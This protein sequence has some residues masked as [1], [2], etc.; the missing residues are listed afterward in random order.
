MPKK[1]VFRI[2]AIK[3]ALVGLICEML[4]GQRNFVLSDFNKYAKAIYRNTAS[5]ILNSYATKD[6]CDDESDFHRNT[7]IES[8]DSQMLTILI[9]NIDTKELREMFRQYDIYSIEINEDGKK[10]IVK[11]IENLQK[12]LFMRYQTQQIMGA[13]RNLIYII[14]RC[15]SLDLDNSALYKTVDMMWS[16]D[17]QRFDMQNYLGM[18]I[19][20]HNPT[21]E[22]ALQFLHKVLDDKSR[23]EYTYII[24]ELC[25]V[26]SK[27]TLRIENI[28]HYITQG[29]NDFNMLPLYSITSG[30]DKSKLIEYGKTSFKECWFPVYVEFMH[31]TQTVPDSVE[32]FEKRLD[33]GK[34]DIESNNAIV[35]KYL[36]EWRKDERYKSLWNIIDNYREKDECLQFFSDP[37]HYAHPERVHIDWITTCPSDIIKEL[38]TQTVYSEKLKNYISDAR[39][40]PQY[41]RVI[42]SVL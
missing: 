23:R 31:K 5:G 38:M 15:A 42:M 30:K 39:I 2:F 18:V 13:V 8:L 4:F 12:G 32:D 9:W 35:C 16:L 37:V 11:C 29:I 22:I 1:I 26:I 40:N 33:K 14:G 17:Y 41:R 3:V 6:H 20:T 36:T 21:P 34:S 25:K 27:S 10:Y 28:E 19:A 7:R 24:E